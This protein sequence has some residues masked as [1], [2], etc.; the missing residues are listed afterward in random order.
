MYLLSSI[1][2]IIIYYFNT[3]RLKNHIATNL[4]G[5]S[6]IVNT[7]SDKSIWDTHKKKNS[8]EK[9]KQ[10]KLILPSSTA[11]ITSTNYH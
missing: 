10:L 1:F 7:D 8:G 3:T 5:N 2:I 6:Y 4:D 11:K 9:A